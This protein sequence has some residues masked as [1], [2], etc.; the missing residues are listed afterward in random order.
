MA[1]K[2]PNKRWALKLSKNYL[3]CLN[4]ISDQSISAGEC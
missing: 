3:E 4:L 1:Q 2:S